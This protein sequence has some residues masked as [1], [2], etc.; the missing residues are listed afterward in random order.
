MDILDLTEYDVLSYIMFL[1]TLFKSPGAVLNYLSG[2]RT[3]YMALLGK[4]SQFDT[5]RVSVFKKGLP[6]T[7]NHVPVPSSP[8]LPD[9]IL[10]MVLVLDE[11]GRSTTP[12]KALLLIAFYSALRQSNLLAR[13][14]KD[15]APHRLLYTDVHPKRDC[16][17]IHI[18]S[19]K[20]IK[21]SLKAC[22]MKLPAIPG[23]PCCPLKAWAD[24][25][26]YAPLTPASP[27]FITRSGEPLLAPRVTA[28]LRLALK[29]SSFK[30]P[31]A[32]TL[33]GLRRGAVHACVAAG[34]TI[35]HIKE[36]GHWK[37]DAVD[38]YLPKKVISSAT[39]TLTSYFG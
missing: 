13:S 36:L 34:S 26:R 28:I 30:D 8:V 29:D 9:Q 4:A 18:R 2:A 1:K 12:V 38:S 16:L 11:L 39:S 22:N 6:R 24:Y 25:E 3:W 19:S 15:P 17:I 7:M 37:S 32:F 27:A 31:K 5:Y 20:T 14:R 33:H 35:T 10:H 21:S 23:S